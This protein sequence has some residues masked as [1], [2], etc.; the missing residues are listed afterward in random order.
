VPVVN[1]DNSQHSHNEN[2]RLGEFRRGIEVDA[3]LIATLDW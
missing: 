1:Y 2:L 3:A